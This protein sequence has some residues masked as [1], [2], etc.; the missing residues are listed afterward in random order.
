MGIPQGKERSAVNTSHT[1]EPTTMSC[2]AALHSLNSLSC[3]RLIRNPGCY[4]LWWPAKSP[5]SGFFWKSASRLVPDGWVELKS[6]GYRCDFRAFQIKLDILDTQNF[7]N[8]PVVEELQPFSTQKCHHAQERIPGAKGLRTPLEPIPWSRIIVTNRHS[9]L[10]ST[11]IVR[12]RNP[13]NRLVVEWKKHE[14]TVFS[15][16]KNS[17]GFDESIKIIN[18]F[19]NLKNV[20][21]FLFFRVFALAVRCI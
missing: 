8:S 17:V 3:A 12:E 14:T 16:L 13:W 4:H 5:D 19:R 9:T 21:I 11:V 10:V 2:K 6:F 20:E 18:I 1:I 7:G 15:K